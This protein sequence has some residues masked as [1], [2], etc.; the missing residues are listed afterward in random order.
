MRCYLVGIVGRQMNYWRYLKEFEQ[1]NG[2]TRNCFHDAQGDG[3]LPH[4]ED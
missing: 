1:I 4:V 3:S 2:Q